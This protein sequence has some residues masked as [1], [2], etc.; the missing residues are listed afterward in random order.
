MRQVTFA[1]VIQKV[2]IRDCL[3]KSIRAQRITRIFTVFAIF[4]MLLDIFMSILES[5]GTL[6]FKSVAENRILL[7]IIAPIPVSVMYS[8]Y[9][10]RVAHVLRQRSRNLSIAECSRRVQFSKRVKEMTFALL[11]YDMSLVAFG[12]VYKEGPQWFWRGAFAALLS[13][14]LL[15]AMRLRAVQRRD[16][17][18]KCS[19]T[20]ISAGGGSVVNGNMT[21]TQTH[22]AGSAAA[23]SRKDDEVI[24]NYSR[25]TPTAGTPRDDVR[26]HIEQQ[27]QQESFGQTGT[28]SNEHIR[29]PGIAGADISSNPQQ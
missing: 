18:Q 2:F 22:R 28:D 29:A 1:V 19:K 5:W 20:N 21:H 13:T 24:V 6:K 14:N 10:R 26:N 27:E 17:V 25:R 3:S 16:N 12:I 9:G 4:I 11:A 8:Y 7:Y 15:A 23:Q